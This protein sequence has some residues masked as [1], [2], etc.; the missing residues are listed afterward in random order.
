MDW[1]LPGTVRS[2]SLQSVTGGAVQDWVQPPGLRGRVK[3]LVRGADM[4]RMDTVN[5][6]FTPEDFQDLRE[7]LVG[8]G[9]TED[10]EACD[11][12]LAAF[13]AAAED[14]ECRGAGGS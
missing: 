3:P 12:I 10:A 5:V 7:A 2:R 9:E 13:D 6:D 1:G 11:R 8:E 4:R 14:A